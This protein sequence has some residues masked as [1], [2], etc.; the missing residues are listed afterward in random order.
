MQFSPLVCL[1]PELVADADDVVALGR[2]APQPGPADANWAWLLIW[3]AKPQSQ[4]QLMGLTP[5]RH[6]WLM[7]MMIGGDACKATASG[8][9]S[10]LAWLRWFPSV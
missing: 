5:A 2:E 6:W 3:V 8:S 9:F 7:L 1:L 4:G 10:W